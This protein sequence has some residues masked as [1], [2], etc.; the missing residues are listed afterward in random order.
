MR[1]IRYRAWYRAVPKLVSLGT[2][3]QTGRF[4]RPGKLVMAKKQSDHLPLFESSNTDLH[5]CMT[6][7]NKCH[8]KLIILRQISLIN[9]IS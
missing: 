7:I 8:V 6:N 4:S 2:Y 3:A 5:T 1:H 9:P